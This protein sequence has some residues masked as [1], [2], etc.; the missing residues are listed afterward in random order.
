MRTYYES[1]EYENENDLGTFTGITICGDSEGPRLIFSSGDQ[2]LF[3]LAI[4]ACEALAM[5]YALGR[6]GKHAIRAAER[7][8]D[9]GV[10]APALPAAT[11]AAPAAI[12]PPA[13]RLPRAADR[14]LERAPAFTPPAAYAGQFGR[15]AA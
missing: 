6:S 2:V 3:D 5:A 12:A 9:E 15:T 14:F 7:L 11:N 10:A 4:P 13:Q 1:S 8:W